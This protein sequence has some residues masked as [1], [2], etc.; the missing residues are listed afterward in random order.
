M[1][2]ISKGKMQVGFTT[3]SPNQGGSLAGLLPFAFSSYY[4]SSLMSSKN[5]IN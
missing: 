2:L 1:A 4:T 3:V 5:S